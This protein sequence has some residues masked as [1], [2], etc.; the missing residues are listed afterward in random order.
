MNAHLWGLTQVTPTRVPWANRTCRFCEGKATH[1][2]TN[3][4]GGADAVERERSGKQR[5]RSGKQ[6]ERSGQREAARSNEN[7]I[8]FNS[9]RFAACSID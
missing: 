2:A 5:E 8:T 3:R 1:G 4:A 6:L 9:Q 7:T